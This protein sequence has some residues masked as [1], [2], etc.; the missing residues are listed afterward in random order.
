MINFLQRCHNSFGDKI[1]VKLLD[2]ISGIISENRLKLL[3]DYSKNL[4]YKNSENLLVNFY[5]E[6]YSLVNQ[7]NSLHNLVIKDEEF[8]SDDKS[9]IIKKLTNIH[10]NL[11]KG[12]DE[13]INYYNI[14]YYIMSLK[15]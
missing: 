10:Q 11:I 13:L 15:Q 2:E 6:G 7:I 8:T 5:N 1:N 4:D 3:L 9:K 14:I 12:C